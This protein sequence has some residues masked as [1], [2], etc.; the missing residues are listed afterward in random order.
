MLMLLLLLRAFVAMVVVSTV[1][2]LLYLMTDLPLLQLDWEQCQETLA[3][4][5]F[6]FKLFLAFQK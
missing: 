4:R 5:Q 1:H 2:I 6:S 3:K